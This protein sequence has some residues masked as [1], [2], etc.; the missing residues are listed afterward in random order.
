MIFFF[1]LL[2]FSLFFFH[3]SPR[4]FYTL[5]TPTPHSFGACCSEK[6][7]SLPYSPFHSSFRGGL[8]Q[9]LGRNKWKGGFIL[10]LNACQLSACIS[11]LPILLSHPR[12]CAVRKYPAVFL[13]TFG[14][15]KSVLGRFLCLLILAKEVQLFIW[16]QLFKQKKEQDGTISG[17]LLLE[18]HQ[19]EFRAPNS[20]FAPSWKEAFCALLTG[21]FAYLMYWNWWA[22]LSLCVRYA[23]SDFPFAGR[24]SITTEINDSA[25][26]PNY[27]CF[28]VDGCVRTLLTIRMTI[29]YFS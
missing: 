27:Y 12:Y 16:H 6:I 10:F 14:R 18:S 24:H 26:I 11:S 1:S 8:F 2:P 3:L 5:L 9:S 28:D 17:P 7:P 29:C 13:N 25:S 21:M 20:S 23:P 22:G 15:V 4:F 19:A